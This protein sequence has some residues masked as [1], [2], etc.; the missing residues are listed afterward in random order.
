MMVLC[1]DTPKEII[2]MLSK[3]DFKRINPGEQEKLLNQLEMVIEKF[4]NY[5]PL[6]TEKC[7]GMNVEL[8]GCPQR[9][10]DIANRNYWSKIRPFHKAIALPFIKNWFEKNLPQ[11][12]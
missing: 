7:L 6:R 9:L 1:N 8:P 2:A 3:I 5:I 11:K 10:I 12:Y 4:R